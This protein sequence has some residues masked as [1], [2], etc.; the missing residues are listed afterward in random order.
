MF[1]DVF[2]GMEWPTFR[3]A[4]VYPCG[5]FLDPKQVYS[6]LN[7]SSPWLQREKL[8]VRAR[9]SICSGDG[10][11]RKHMATRERQVP[12]KISK[13]M[14]GY[15]DRSLRLVPIVQ[16]SAPLLRRSQ[17]C[18]GCPSRWFSARPSTLGTSSCTSLFHLALQPNLKSCFLLWALSFP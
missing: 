8:A 5:S 13:G 4:R 14:K 6:T 3:T 16:L 2:L 15:T 7:Q 18:P 10:A 11:E 12:F 9:T 17:C 1:N